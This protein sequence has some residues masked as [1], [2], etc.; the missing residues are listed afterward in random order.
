MNF[1]ALLTHGPRLSNE[2]KKA[3]TVTAQL[4]IKTCQRCGKTKPLSSFALTHVKGKAYLRGK[5][6][7]CT[8][9]EDRIRRSKP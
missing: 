1:A 6:V 7:I 2:A 8:R 4:T 9:E 3:Q 5:C